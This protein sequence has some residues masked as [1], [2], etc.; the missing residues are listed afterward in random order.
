MGW[1]GDFIDRLSEFDREM[2]QVVVDSGA[3][4]ILFC[5]RT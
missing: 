4:L 3:R 5:F 2:N 1:L